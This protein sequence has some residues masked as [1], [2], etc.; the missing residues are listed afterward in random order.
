MTFFFKDFHNKYTKI[1][2]IFMYLLTIDVLTTFCNQRIFSE[3]V[4]ANCN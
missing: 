1:Y 3:M 4:E 2:I